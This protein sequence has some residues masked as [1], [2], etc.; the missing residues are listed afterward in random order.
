MARKE[1]PDFGAS[2]ALAPSTQIVGYVGKKTPTFGIELKSGAFFAC[3]LP[4]SLAR[5]LR[6]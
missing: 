4:C 2:R 6:G 1:A 5:P 3:Y